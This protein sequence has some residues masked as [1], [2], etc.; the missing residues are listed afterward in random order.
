MWELKLM[1]SHPNLAGVGFGPEVDN[2]SI[3]IS[4][5]E[6]KRQVNRSF[7]FGDIKKTRTSS[8]SEA[9]TCDN[10]QTELVEFY[11][12]SFKTMNRNEKYKVLVMGFYTENTEITQIN[13]TISIAVQK[14]I[15]ETKRFPQ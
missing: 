15:F 10:V 2:L 1:L 13:V 11:L 6:K 14:F 12:P 8:D 3:D 9:A 5:W 7:G 4:F